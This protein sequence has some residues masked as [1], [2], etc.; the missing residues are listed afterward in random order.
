MGYLA[1]LILAAVVGG[2]VYLV[3]SEQ[4][5][6]H[7]VLLGGALALIAANFLLTGVL[8]VAEPD[9]GD[10]FL[11]MVGVF[12]GSYDIHPLVGAIAVGVAI[13][14]GMW[15]GD[16]EKKSRAQKR[17]TFRGEIDVSRASGGVTLLCEF[18]AASNRLRDTGRRA[19]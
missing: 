11:P 2:G 19:A 13:F 4:A 10:L 7:A 9:H 6:I 1:A 8:A 5:H 15:A 18:D 14:L 12:V 17:L 16:S 3:V